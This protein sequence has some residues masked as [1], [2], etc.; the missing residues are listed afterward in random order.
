MAK[1]T[2][3]LFSFSASGQIAKSLVYMKWKGIDDVR[4][5]VI[6]ANPKSANQLIQRGYFE[7]G[8][9]EWQGAAFNTLDVAAWNRLASI[10]SKVMSGFNVMMKKFVDEAILGNTWTRLHTVVVS[11]IGTNGFTVAVASAAGAPGT[12]IVWGTSKT[13]FAGYADMVDGGAGTWSYAIGGLI[14]DT[15]YF[16]WILRGATGVNYG[17]TGLYMQKTAA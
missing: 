9:T 2:A 16:F 1:V 6:P 4:K 15:E 7:D 5:Y 8:V 10:Q 11:A 17:R 13:Y 14:P 12:S 3:P